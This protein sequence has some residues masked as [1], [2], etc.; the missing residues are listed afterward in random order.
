MAYGMMGG[1]GCS[2]LGM[3]G[4]WI[5][6]LIFF[7]IASFAFSAIFWLTYNWLVKDKMK[8]K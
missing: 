6:G 3:A 5:L 7:V 2:P 4:M 8:K 1:Y